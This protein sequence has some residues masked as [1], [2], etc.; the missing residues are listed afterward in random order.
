MTKK[1]NHDARLRRVGNEGSQVY[2]T[3]CCRS[4]A[5]QPTKELAYESY[6]EKGG[7]PNESLRKEVFG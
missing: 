4:W 3:K 5:V 2:C 6:L 7:K 1:C